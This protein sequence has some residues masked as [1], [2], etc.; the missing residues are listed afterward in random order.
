M[1]CSSVNIDVEAW[2][3]E[4]V[5]IE[6]GRFYSYNGASVP[7]R[8]RPAPTP[9]GAISDY[10]YDHDGQPGRKRHKITKIAP[11]PQLPKA[12]D[13]TKS[14]RRADALPKED[15]ACVLCPDMSPEGL[16]RV[17]DTGNA[18]EYFAHRICA[19]F[20]PETWMDGDE[21]RGFGGIERAR[22]ALK[23][24]LC[25]NPHGTK[26]QSFTIFRREIDC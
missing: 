3:A 14:F 15:Y 12:R 21:I 16:V 11:T 4:A 24:A 13:L 10:V 19:M 8:K 17:L 6:E 18:G 5:A 2:L 20:T 26:S 9:R 22:W 1:I 25:S 7:R 23:C